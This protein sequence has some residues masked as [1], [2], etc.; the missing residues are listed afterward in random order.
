M[1]GSFAHAHPSFGLSQLTWSSLRSILPVAAVVAL[2]VISQTAATTRGAADQGGYDVDVARDFIGV[3]A[4]SV[5]AGLAGSFPVDASPPNTAAVASAGG[6][7]Q[8]AGLG[9]AAVVAAVLIPAASLLKDVPLATLAAVLIFVAIRIFHVRDFAAVLHFDKWEFGLAVVTA[10]TVATI[11][12]EQGIWVAVGLAVLDRAR[13]S[14]RPKAHL[15]GRIPGTTSWEPLESGQQRDEVPGVLVMLFASPLYFANADHFRA[16]IETALGHPR[17]R[18]RVLVLDV[19]GMHD[20][21]FTGTRTLRSTLDRLDREQIAFALA[22]AGEHLVEN[23][24][25]SGLLERIGTDHL[26]PSVDAAV[27]ALNPQNGR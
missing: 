18:P 5:L 10:L 9:A 26:F 8:L 13:L 15:M 11:G 17:A 12:V 2:V 25:R 16:Q 3:G 22:R 23:L 14:A 21:D 20:V 6:R 7:T 19:V 27:R 1:L 24:A 4:G